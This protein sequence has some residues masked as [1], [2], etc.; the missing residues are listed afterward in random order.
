MSSEVDHLEKWHG[1]P[2]FDFPDSEEGADSTL[3]GPDEVAWRVSGD[4]HGT[5]EEWEEAFARF[6][7]AVDTTRVRALIVGEWSEPYDSD[8]SGVIEVLISARER[9]SGLRAVFLGDMHA[10]QCEISWINQTDVTPLLTAFPELLEFGARG[11][12]GLRFPPLRHDRLR[13]LIFQSGGLPAEAVRG[14][15]GSDLPALEHLELW[16]GVH[17]YHGDAEAGDLDRLLSGTAFPALRHLGLR[18]SEI[19][20]DIAAAVASSPLVARLRSLDLSLGAL[21]DA[22]ASALLDGQPLTHLDRLDLHHNYVTQA[23]VQR[24]ENALKPAGVELDLSAGDAV[25]DELDDSRVR[26]YTAVSE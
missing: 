24:I 10:E 3:P 25:Q 22:G 5:G 17:R 2:V 15:C 20:D 1:L 16:L 7:E 23:M 4:E 19:Q 21:T 18:N 12:N 11:G 13:T 6:T 8:C 14:V 26:R 9:F